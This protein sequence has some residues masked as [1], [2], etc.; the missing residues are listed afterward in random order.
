MLSQNE[1]VCRHEKKVFRL[2][3]CS[4]K[5]MEHRKQWQTFQTVHSSHCA[6][7]QEQTSED[8]TT[9]SRELRRCPNTMPGG[10]THHYQSIN[11]QKPGLARASAAAAVSTARDSTS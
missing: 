9:G 8:H 10:N 2:E 3:L 6:I 4:I 7:C 11:T 1:P 5:D